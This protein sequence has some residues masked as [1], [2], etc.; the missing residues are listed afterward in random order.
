MSSKSSDP[1]FGLPTCSSLFAEY[2]AHDR[3]FK[4][5]GPRRAAALFD[6]FG[7]DIRDALLSIDDRVVDI[8]GEENAIIAAAV[9]TSRLAETNFLEWLTRLKAEVP[10]HKAIRIARAWGKQGTEAI[11]RN[12]YL[13]LAVCD[14]KTVDLIASK[15]GIARQDLRRDIAAI[16]AALTGKGGLD[17][18]STLMTLEH[19]LRRAQRLS[20][21]IIHPEVA[22]HAVRAAAAVRLGGALQPPGAAHMEAGCALLLSKLG[23]QPPCS[24]I[25]AA[26]ALEDLVADYE[27]R[28]PFSLTEA[29][30]EAVRMAHRHRLLVLAGYAGS[31]KTTVLKGVCET[32]EAIRKRCLIVTLSGRAA[33]RAAEATGR[34]ALTVARFLIEEGKSSTPL[35]SDWVLIVDEAS[36]LGLVEFWR[37]LRRL[38]DASLVLCGDPA[39]LPPVSPGVVFHHLAADP[40]IQ[41]VV[42]D[43]VHR[44]DQLTGIPTLAE[45][46]RNGTIARLPVFSGPKPGVTFVSCSRDE[47]CDQI[48]RIGMEMAKGG[49]DRNAMQIIA[50][51]NREI[52]RINRYFHNRLLRKKPN[53][54]PGTQHIAEGEPVI[55]TQNDTKRGLSNG[56]LG[57]IFRINDQEITAVI[58]GEKRQLHPRDGQFLQ[59]AW[60]IS[61]HKA[62][63][64]QWPCVIIPIFQSMIVDRSLIYT[65]L[66]RAQEQIVFVG[67][68]SAAQ[69]AVQRKTAAE[70][71]NCGFSSWMKLAHA[72]NDTRAN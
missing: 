38:G 39:Q 40:R 71:R 9:L 27:K 10:I 33:Q 62:Q 19:V 7:P 6:V 31:G 28:Q 57:R 64:S 18:G 45:G 23:P 24:G 26:K 34:R 65:A 15:L 72:F 29:Q 51:T 67:S 30:R 3:A 55:W 46:I 54:W 32:Q 21:H 25:T 48:L 61:V 35:G 2:L 56:A 70:S 63:G 16:E 22:N 66:T 58:D 59:P 68:Y 4:G 1:Q 47:L 11:M 17:S 12:P 8:I 13:L 41:K 60:A 14:W 36:M 52:D 42:L 44:Q 20:G 50:P 69:R 43:R 49:I 53:L 37:I 5:I